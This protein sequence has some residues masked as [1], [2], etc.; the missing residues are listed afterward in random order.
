MAFIGGGTMI[1]GTPTDAPVM[2]ELLGKEYETFLFSIQHRWILN[3]LSF[4]YIANKIGI[5]HYDIK[6]YQRY[7]LGNAIYWL[8]NKVPSGHKKYKFISDGLDAL[9]KH[10]LE[11]QELADYIVFKCVRK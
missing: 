8:L 9:W 4:K 11:R 3:K 10:E 1:I 2:R 7:G 6:F 5:T